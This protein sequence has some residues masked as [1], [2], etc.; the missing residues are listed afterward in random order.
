MISPENHNLKR[1]K[2][3]KRQIC[4]PRCYLLFL[5]ECTDENKE[6]EREKKMNDG[7]VFEEYLLVKFV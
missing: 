2:K 1:K 3:T 4:L 7:R 5:F 6:R